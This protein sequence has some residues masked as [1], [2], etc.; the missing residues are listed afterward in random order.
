[1]TLLEVRDLVVAY[2][3]IRALHGLS[4]EVAEGEMVTLIGANGA[5]KSTTLWSMVGQ[6][7][8]LG[9]RVESG[10]ATFRGENLLVRPAHEVVT[11]LGVCLVPEGRRVFGNLTVLENLRLGA[12]ARRDK[13]GVAADLERVVGLF[14]R[15][16]E[17][18]DQLA[19]LLSGGEQQMLAVGRALMTRPRVLLLDEPSM[20][21]APVLVKQVFDTLVEINKAGTTMLLVEQNAHMALRHADRAYVLQTG[22]VVMAGP[23]ADIA[24]NKEVQRAY[25]GT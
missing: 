17:R 16:D 22:A 5:G 11:R 23:A 25:L 4:F 20:G 2:G 6:L 9:G 7:R 12:F 3:A 19:D 8:E 24:G 1:V 21:L 10:T 18:K 14:P 15:L 13:A